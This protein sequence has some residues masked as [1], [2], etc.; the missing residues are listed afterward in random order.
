MKIGVLINLNAFKDLI[1]F[2][3]N[4]KITENMLNVSIRY[5]KTVNKLFEIKPL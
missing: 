4:S 3:S 5:K 2:E 1:F